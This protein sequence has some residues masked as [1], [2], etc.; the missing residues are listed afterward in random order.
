MVLITDGEDHEGKAIDLAKQASKRGMII[1]TV[2]VGTSSGSLIPVTSSNGSIDYKKDKD[3]RLVTSQ[4]NED[5]LSN[6]SDAGNGIFLRFNNK[7][8]NFKNLLNEIDSM[9]KRSIA[10]HVYSEFEDQYQKFGLLS[11]SLMTI[12][13]MIG[14]QRK[15]S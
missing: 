13:M 2:G 11:L 5:I 14:S 1:H 4:L 15:K 10:S 3:G 8:A 6:I 9:E 12:G 7:P